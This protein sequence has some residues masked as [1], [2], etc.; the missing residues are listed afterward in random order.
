LIYCLTGGG[1][2]LLG[3]SKV[4]QKCCCCLSR[5]VLGLDSWCRFNQWVARVL[6]LDCAK[7]CVGEKYESPNPWAQ[8]VGVDISG[9]VLKSASVRLLKVM[10]LDVDS[11]ALN[12][13]GQDFD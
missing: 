8:W 9:G 12:I 10:Q 7:G 6:E 4:V 3:D 2:D 13:A 5:H 11:D 1:G